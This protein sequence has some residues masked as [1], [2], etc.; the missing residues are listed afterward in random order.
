MLRVQVYKYNNIMLWRYECGTTTVIVLSG[1]S[2][3]I[4]QGWGVLLAAQCDCFFVQRACV[5]VCV[6]FFHEYFYRG[7]RIGTRT[8]SLYIYPDDYTTGTEKTKQG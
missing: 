2:Q 5:R 8:Y 7:R 4:T 3:Q 1:F 6:F